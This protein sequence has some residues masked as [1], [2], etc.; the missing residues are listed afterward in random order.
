MNLVLPSPPQATTSS[1]TSVWIGR[2]L[3]GIIA[4]FLL[5]AHGLRN[6][7]LRGLVLS[8]RSSK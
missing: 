3:T 6:P 4:S 7:Q 5:V 1:R 8:P 2:V